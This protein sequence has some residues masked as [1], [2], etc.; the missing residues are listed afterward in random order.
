MWYKR[1]REKLIEE[2]IVYSMFT[3]YAKPMQSQCKANAK[4][5]LKMMLNHRSVYKKVILPLT[6]VE[7][8]SVN[9][10]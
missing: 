2:T 4:H 7:Y 3:N 1:E 5:R 10:S 8:Y 9:R 6:L